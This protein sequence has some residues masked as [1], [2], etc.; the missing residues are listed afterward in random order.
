[1]LRLL[2]IGLL[3]IGLSGSAQERIVEV[4][5]KKFNV[6]AMGLGNRRPGQPVVVFENGMGVDLKNWR[7]VFDQV[8]SFAPVVAYDRAGIGK[9]DNLYQL[10]TPKLVAENLHGI[11]GVLNIPPPYVLVGHSLGGLYVRGFAGYYP[12]DVAG[13]VFVDPADF[14]ETRDDWNAI[15]KKL[16]L[17]D[18]RIDEMLQDRLY[19]S[20]P[21][22]DSLNY[23]PRSERYALNEL[24]KSDFAEI[25]ALPLPKVP[26]YFFVGGK[27][28]V[29]LAQRSKEYDQQAFFHIKNSSNMDRW[30][31]LIH[32][33]G[34]PGAVIY[35]SHSGH[36]IQWDDPVSLIENIRILLDGVNK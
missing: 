36:Y 29:P 27:F 5:G 12:G 19:R 18:K 3:L 13:L 11:L 8:G 33:T 10:P 31:Q 20:V 15:F 26:I 1:M 34:R 4:K 17:T 14:T 22:T 9:S 21:I 6:K 2:V 24:R 35:L 25:A 23:G 28:D 32:A 16:G 7:T 30:R